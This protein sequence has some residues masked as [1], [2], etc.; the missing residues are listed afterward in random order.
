M[1]VNLVLNSMESICSRKDIYF[2]TLNL[3]IND[4]Q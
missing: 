2:E 1:T 3:Y 4:M